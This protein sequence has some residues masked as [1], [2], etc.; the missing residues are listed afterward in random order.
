MVG[1][2]DAKPMH[3]RARSGRQRKDDVE[4]IEHGK[5]APGEP[6]DRC[7]DHDSD[8]GSDGPPCKDRC[9]LVSAVHGRRWCR[10]ETASAIH[11]QTASCGVLSQPYEA[12]GA[13]CH[14]GVTR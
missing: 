11:V 14:P 7:G 6:L 8:A 2:C 1:H 12:H 10:P 4:A 9:V 13:M 5:V 3:E